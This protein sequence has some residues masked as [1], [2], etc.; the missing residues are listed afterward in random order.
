MN[1]SLFRDLLILSPSPS[2]LSG[3][4]IQDVAH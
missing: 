2:P 1:I 4:H 3:V